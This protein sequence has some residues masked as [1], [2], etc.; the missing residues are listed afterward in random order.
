MLLKGQGLDCPL[1]FLT[2]AHYFS[3]SWMPWFTDSLTSLQTPVIPSHQKAACGTPTWPA[4]SWLW[5]I[6][7]CFLGTALAFHPLFGWRLWKSICPSPRRGTN[8][9]GH[10]DCDRIHIHVQK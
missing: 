8:F 5:L 3:S 6:P 1:N 2:V 7:S 10:D 4:G 9:S